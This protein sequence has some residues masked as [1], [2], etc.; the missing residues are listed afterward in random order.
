MAREENLRLRKSTV[1]RYW[2]I[3]NRSSSGSTLNG[4]QTEAVPF[5]ELTLRLLR[6]GRAIWALPRSRLRLKLSKLGPFSVRKSQGKPG[7]ISESS[8]LTGRLLSGGDIPMSLD[9]HDAHSNPSLN[10]SRLGTWSKWFINL[11][12]HRSCANHLGSVV[13]AKRG[14]GSEMRTWSRY[15]GVL[16]VPVSTR[17]G[18]CQPSKDHLDDLSSVALELTI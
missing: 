8:V 9:V 13:R 18:W 17:K 4:S 1:E 11:C 3:S 5:I 10:L 15:M 14:G 16:K 7:A 12:Q 6:L 2:A